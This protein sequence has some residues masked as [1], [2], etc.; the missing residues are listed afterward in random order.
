MKS[1]N[2]FF[3]NARNDPYFNRI[4]FLSQSEKINYSLF[5]YP[6]TYNDC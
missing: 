1:S 2:F 6:A 5:K 4:N 3:M